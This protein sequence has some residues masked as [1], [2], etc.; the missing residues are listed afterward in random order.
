MLCVERPIARPAR[1]QLQACSWHA[2]PRCPEPLRWRW[3]CLASCS[4]TS[5]ALAASLEPLCI[6]PKSALPVP[7]GHACLQVQSA[8]ATAPRSW[9]HKGAAAARALLGAPR[10]L[11]RL[12]RSAL[13]GAVVGLTEQHGPLTGVRLRGEACIALCVAMAV[14]GHPA[15]LLT[16]EPRAPAGGS[17][18][19]LVCLQPPS[20]FLAS[21]PSHCTLLVLAIAWAED[22]DRASVS[23]ASPGYASAPC[24][25]APCRHHRAAGFKTRALRVGGAGSLAAGAAVAPREDSHVP[26]EAAAA[27]GSRAG[28]V[29]AGGVA[30][31]GQAALEL[32]ATPAVRPARAAPAEPG[33]ATRKRS[34]DAA[35][36]SALA[37]CTP[38]LVATVQEGGQCRHASPAAQVLR[39]SRVPAVQAGRAPGACLC[40]C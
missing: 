14:A 4:P 9:M 1:Q 7:L 34:A 29:G 22:R 25:A 39:A 31:E 26:L 11:H 15:R 40:T 13:V 2:Q 3:R 32:A 33:A 24:L 30:V 20:W 28:Q 16:L 6:V 37:E 8:P 23:A 12:D 18:Y 35:G 10:P 38:K 27:P 5:R 21:S 36:S 19:P 17:Q